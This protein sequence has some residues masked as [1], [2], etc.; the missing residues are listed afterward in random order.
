MTG[1][2]STIKVD[3][4][5]VGRHGQIDVDIF[6]RE[7]SLPQFDVEPSMRLQL[8]KEIGVTALSAVNLH[9]RS[10]DSLRPGV[11]RPVEAPGFY[12]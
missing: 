1:M 12:L 2:P 7:I 9:Q 5:P 3:R 6:A 8:D 11:E 4:S 10:E